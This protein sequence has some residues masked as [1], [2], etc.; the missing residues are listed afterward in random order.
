M[1]DRPR[2]TL[3]CSGRFAL[4][5]LAVLFVC[6]A[7]ALV[8]HDVVRVEE[9]WELVLGEPDSNSAGPQVA[10]T[11]SPFSNLSDTYF[12]IEINHRSVPYWSPGGISIHHWCGEWRMDSFD[13]ADRTIMQTN[14]ET[15]RW[16]QLLEVQGGLL[17][18]QVKNG[19]SSTWGPFGYSNMLK[20]Q[21]GWGVNNINSYSADVSV[22]NSGVSYAGNRVQSLKLKEVR[23]ILSDG[24]VLIDSTVRTVHPQQ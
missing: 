8:A 1:N 4:P 17:T 2:S 3:S 6:H 20:L 21:R 15:V 12:T 5:L 9:D 22:G 23:A 19:S 14:N 18:F 13:R 24:S 10:C 16:T 11:M 7:A